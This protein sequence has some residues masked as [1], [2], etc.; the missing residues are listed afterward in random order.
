[1]IPLNSRKV[2][3]SHFAY[4]YLQTMLECLNVLS[5]A[6]SIYKFNL[7][8]YSTWLHH[9]WVVTVENVEEVNDMK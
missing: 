6:K 2:E 8:S 9:M 5:S 1:M 3:P 4:H 7:F